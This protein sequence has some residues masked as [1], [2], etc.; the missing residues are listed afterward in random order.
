MSSYLGLWVRL[1]L[2]DRKEEEVWR[3]STEQARDVDGVQSVLDVVL[4]AL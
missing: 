3:G 1:C 2:G 4:I